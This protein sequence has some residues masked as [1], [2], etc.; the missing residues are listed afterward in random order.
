MQT[1]YYETSSFIRHEGNVVDL[2]LYRSKLSAVSGGDW[3]TPEEVLQ[4]VR[5][6][7]P[8]PLL[9][10]VPEQSAAAGASRR[11]KRGVRRLGIALD[12]CASL[13]ILAMTVTAVVQFLRLI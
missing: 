11:R 10:L 5:A 8:A 6:E 13:A 7:E 9:T 3:P 4:P 1:I 2:A 12:L